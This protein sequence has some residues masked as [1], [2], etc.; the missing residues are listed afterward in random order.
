[1]KGLLSLDLAGAER[2]AMFS[3]NHVSAAIA[4]VT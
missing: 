3:W 2:H 4:A 1:M